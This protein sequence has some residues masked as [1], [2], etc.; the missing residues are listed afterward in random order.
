MDLDPAQLKA[1][2]AVVDEGSFEGAARA[3]S[4]TPSAVSQRIKALERAAGHVVVRRARPCEPTVPGRA[5]LR[6]AREWSVLEAEAA[7]VLGG[8]D[9][10]AHVRLA[11]AVNAD[12]LSTWFPPVLAGLPA[13]VLL[14]VRR[15]DQD[16]SA[17]LLREGSV[18]AAVTTDSAPV[19]GCR[20]HH[21]GDMR[22]LAVAAPAFVARWLPDGPTPEALGRA[23]LLAF[24]GKDALQDRFAAQ[25][26]GRPADPPRHLVPSNHA[27]V[28]LVA[29]GL[30]WGMVPEQAARAGVARGGLVEL[31][32]GHHLDV[33]LYW[34][35]WKVGS[36]WLDVLT[37]RAV[38]HA[39]HELQRHVRGRAGGRER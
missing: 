31:A 15:E 3:L 18:M 19:Q 4:V 26:T 11:I 17:A 27:F 33:P 16:H 34:Q 20:V 36:H 22:Y 21:L 14:D 23:P 8:D 38:D 2:A 30:G 37:R 6:L 28:E 1:L 25:L 35:H 12:S 29:H 7:G 13:H 10:D 24:T 5:L 39:G 32:P 9:P